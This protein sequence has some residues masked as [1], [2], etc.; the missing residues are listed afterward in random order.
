MNSRITLHNAQNNPTA[1]SAVLTV[2]GDN[3]DFNTA[4][5]GITINNFEQ[6]LTVRFSLYGT[7]QNT[8]TPFGNISLNGAVTSVVITEPTGQQ[9]G[10]LQ[11]TNNQGL[12]CTLS[13]RLKSGA[14]TIYDLRNPTLL[15]P[16]C[17][18]AGQA[19]S[20]TLK[21]ANMNSRIT[22]HNAQ[23]N[24][25]PTAPSAV[26]TVQGDNIDL[27]TAPA[28]VTINNFEQDRTVRFS[29][30]GTVQNTYTPLQNLPL[31]GAVT[32]VIIAEP[33]GVYR[34]VLTSPK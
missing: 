34:T 19:T 17:Q 29:L 18:N 28:G 20:I 7:V 32:S 27:N 26:L 4:P 11:L 22:L 9:Y 30:Y 3:I 10:F 2:Q 21:R 8:Y 6:D 25:N 12:S 13:W 31:N 15:P 1:P 33:A 5:A 24:P 14:T 23:N 16:G